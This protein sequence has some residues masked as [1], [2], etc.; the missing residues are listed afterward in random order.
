[1]YA[2]RIVEYAKTSEI[3]LKPLHPYTRGLLNSLPQHTEPGQLLK[4][5]PGQVPNLLAEL[6]GC[7]FCERCPDKSW[8][9]HEQKPHMK[10]IGTDHHVR[11]WKFA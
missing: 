2:G 5:I 6:Q 9:C 4:T 3:F 8:I 11:C 10:E 7:G 1:M